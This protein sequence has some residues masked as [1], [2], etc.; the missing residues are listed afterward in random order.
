M[1][2]SISTLMGGGV[3]IVQQCDHDDELYDLCIPGSALDLR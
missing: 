3:N 2:C 1:G